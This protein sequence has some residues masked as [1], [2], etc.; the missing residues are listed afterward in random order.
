MKQRILRWLG[1]DTWMAGIER[2]VGESRIL[3]QDRVL[4]IQRENEMLRQENK[5][6]LE[7]FIALKT[8][9]PKPLEGGTRKVNA[10]WLAQQHTARAFAQDREG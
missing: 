10:A 9:P 4:T 3:V 7:A 5:A 8:E 6:L 1:L 2:E